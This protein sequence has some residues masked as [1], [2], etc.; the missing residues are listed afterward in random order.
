V[1]LGIGTVQFGLDYGITNAGGRTHAAEVGAILAECAGHGVDTLD[2]AALYGESESVLGEH[3]PRP[4]RFQIVSKTLHLDAELPLPK[5]LKAIRGGVMQSLARLRE[6]SLH[7]LLIHRV[8]DLLGPA[9]DALF[10]ELMTLREEG[11]V[12][13]IGVS[14]YTPDEVATLSGRYPLEIVQ[15]PLNV[16]DQRMLETGMLAA[17]RARNIKIHVR[18]AFLQGVLLVDNPQQLPAGLAA[19]EPALHQFNERLRAY[20]ISPLAGTLGFLNSLNALDVVVCGA[21]RLSEWREISSAF[22]TLPLLPNELFKDLAQ[23]DVN[24]IDPRRWRRQPAR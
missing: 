22:G 24:L 7:A 14:V 20:G 19:L 18:S 10:S 11:L 12:K 23:S 6:P 4:H 3:L 9:G 21:S 8:D 13:K 15:L 1:K 5:A 2:T 17:L 16:F